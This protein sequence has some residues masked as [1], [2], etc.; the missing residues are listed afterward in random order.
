[1]VYGGI[2]RE[3]YYAGSTFQFYLDT[4]YYMDILGIIWAIYDMESLIRCKL[5][6]LRKDS[7]YMLR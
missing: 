4:A 6:N 7:R 2:I 5:L 1:M 3:L